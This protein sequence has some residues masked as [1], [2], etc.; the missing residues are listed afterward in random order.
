M[1]LKK[2]G[3]EGGES[4]L[5]DKLKDSKLMFWS[6]ECLILAALLLV[7]KKIDFVFSPI[8]TLVSTLFA[9][10]VVAGIF[11]YMLNPLVNLLTKFKIKRIWAIILVFLLVIVLLVI[12]I[13]S[14][15]PSLVEQ[16]GYLARN[17]PSFVKDVEAWIDKL[18]QNPLLEKIDIDEYWDKL[19]LS[20]TQIAQKAVSGVSNSF[21]P[22]ISSVATISVI[23]ITSPFI[24]FYM[25]KDGDQFI[26]SIQKFLPKKRE[27]EVSELLRKMSD[28]ISAYISGQALECLSVGVLTMIGYYLIGIKDYAVLFGTIA[29]IANI[30]PYLGPYLGLAPAVLVTV[31]NDP[32]QALLACIVVLI[33]QQIDG[34]IIYPNIMGKKLEIHPLTIIFILLVAGNLAGLTGMILGVPFYAVG[35]TV[36]IYI[37]DIIRINQE[38]RQKS[39]E[40]ESEKELK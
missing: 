38:V 7:L 40:I 8:G 18:M 21:G 14:I 3:I 27:A 36:V 10:I 6:L 31:F 25:L 29:G 20:L 11:F 17:L 24:L 30:I 34:N 5:W 13:G 2:I 19:D 26:P 32:F 33:V 22:V 39:K 23:V 4:F 16:V 1:I 12:F 9:P 35:K 28:T 37:A 15:V